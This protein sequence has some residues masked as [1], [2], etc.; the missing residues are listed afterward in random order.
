MR[1]AD[2]MYSEPNGS[3]RAW[4]LEQAGRPDRVGD[5]ANDVRDDA[6]LGKQRTPRSILAHIQVEHEP[7]VDA[8]AAFRAAVAEWKAAK[9]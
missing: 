4:L 2:V 9:P 6:C 5:L 3:F 8:I 1:A 7:S